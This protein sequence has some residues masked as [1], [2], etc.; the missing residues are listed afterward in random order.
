M[1]IKLE[2]QIKRLN[3]KE[4][5]LLTL[6]NQLNADVFDNEDRKIVSQKI[7]ETRDMKQTLEVTLIKKRKIYKNQIQGVEQHLK[8]R[9]QKLEQFDKT[10]GIIFQ[11]FPDVLEFFARKQTRLNEALVGI[12]EKLQE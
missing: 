2:G 11:E 10:Q 9:E 8:A 1:F 5:G 7:I 12:R 4:Q 6:A 3:E